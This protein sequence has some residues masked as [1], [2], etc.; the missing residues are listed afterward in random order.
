MRTAE[1]LDLAGLARGVLNAPARLLAQQLVGPRIE[2]VIAHRVEIE[3]DAVHRLDRRFVE[4]ERRDQ[5]R[6][7]DHVT[8]RDGQMVRI[9][10]ADRVD[11][12]G[13]ICRAPGR[14]RD[15]RPIGQRRRDRLLRHLQ[16]AVE[17]VDRDDSHFDRPDLD[18]R[19]TPAPRHRRGAASQG[20]GKQRSKAEQRCHDGATLGETGFSGVT[21]ASWPGAKGS[22]PVH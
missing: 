10:G 8:R 18:R 22:P 12:A 4:I 17:I 15:D 14:N 6:S 2:L 9:L 3:A 11:R 20:N 1:R 5:R 21:S 13:Q 16:R 19:A 7:A